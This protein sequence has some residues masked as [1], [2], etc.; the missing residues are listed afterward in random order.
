MEI[1]LSASQVALTDKH[2]FLSFGHWGENNTQLAAWV[3]AQEDLVLTMTVIWQKSSPSPSC[4]YT[5]IRQTQAWIFRFLRPRPAPVVKLNHSK[6]IWAYRPGILPS[7]IP[8]ESVHDSRK[9]PQIKRIHVSTSRLIW[10][11]F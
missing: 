2:S 6:W 11:K 5:S 3:P 9:V 7:G 10:S 4:A 8:K 1:D